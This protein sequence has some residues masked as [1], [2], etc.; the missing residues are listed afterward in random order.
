MIRDLIRIYERSVEHPYFMTAMRPLSYIALL[1][2][3]QEYMF[4][5]ESPRGAFDTVT[6][7]YHSLR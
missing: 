2:P 5:N 1:L 6:R 4:P 7:Q 3:L